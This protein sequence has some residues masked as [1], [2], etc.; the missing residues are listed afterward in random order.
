MCMQL[1]HK[2]CHVIPQQDS[3]KY[4]ATVLEYKAYN[5]AGVDVF[6]SGPNNSGITL[7][8]DHIVNHYVSFSVYVH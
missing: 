6:A 5:I 8:H 7:S 4:L 3:P 2:S 1:H